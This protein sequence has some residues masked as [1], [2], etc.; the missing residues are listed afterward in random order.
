MYPTNYILECALVND[1]PFSYTTKFLK[2]YIFGK[3]SKNVRST[4]CPNDAIDLK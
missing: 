3:L 2:H 4:L 1:M